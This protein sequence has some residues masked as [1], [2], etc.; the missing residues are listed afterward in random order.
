[1]FENSEQHSSSS[2]DPLFMFY[3]CLKGK[4]ANLD[5]VTLKQATGS[6]SINDGNGNDNAI[7]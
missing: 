2:T 5:V 3:N 7:N 6:F 1:M 4:D